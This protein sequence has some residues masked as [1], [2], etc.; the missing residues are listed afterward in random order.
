VIVVALDSLR[1]SQDSLSL[2]GIQSPVV[3]YPTTRELALAKASATPQSVLIGSNGR[4]LAAH[5]GLV[6]D[7]VVSLFLR[8]AATPR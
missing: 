8:A 2:G 6:T 1:A 7:S 3:A 5:T 4:I